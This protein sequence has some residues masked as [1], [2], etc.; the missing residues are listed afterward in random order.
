M[1]FYSRPSSAELTLTDL[2]RMTFVSWIKV[3]N[4]ELIGVTTGPFMIW[5]V[6]KAY[7]KT[8]SYKKTWSYKLWSFWDDIHWCWTC[9]NAF[10]VLWT[11]LGCYEWLST[12][13]GSMLSQAIAKTTGRR[14]WCA[15]WENVFQFICK[16]YLEYE[17]VVHFFSPE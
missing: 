12:N 16:L 9:S 6:R 7:P 1:L 14:W 3:H 4:L 15:V 10:F 17:N 11:D 5:S 8:S 13:E 2:L